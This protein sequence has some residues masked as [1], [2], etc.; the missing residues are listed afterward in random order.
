MA[1][2]KAKSAGMAILAMAKLSVAACGV[3][4]S[5]RIMKPAAAGGGVA[6][7]KLAVISNGGSGGGASAAYGNGN[8]EI[9]SV[10]RR[11]RRSAA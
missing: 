7:S 2:V 5:C 1:Y 4:E 3:I 6:A 8:E 10:R 9:T 11:W